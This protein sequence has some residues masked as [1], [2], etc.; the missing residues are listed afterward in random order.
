MNLPGGTHL[1]Y[2][3]TSKAW[4]WMSVRRSGDA[5]EMTVLASS[6]PGRGC[7][8]EFRVEEHDLGGPGINPDLSGLCTRLLIF[9]DA[10]AAFAD[11]PEFFTL[12]RERR[13]GTLEK[14][15]EILDGLGAA[16]ET[17]R[18]RGAR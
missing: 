18:V 9:E 13:P 5:P 6:G 4:Y 12:M 1:A 3:M 10:Y 8:W 14:V 16:D 2:I 17:P 7:I 11:I 15:R